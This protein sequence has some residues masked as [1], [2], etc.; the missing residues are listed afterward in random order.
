MDHWDENFCDK[1]V[2]DKYR[3]LQFVFTSFNDTPPVFTSQMRGLMY[4]PEVAPT[5]GRKHWQGWVW[6]KNAHTVGQTY[7]ALNNSWC[8]PARA[9]YK[10]N[11]DYIEGPYLKGSKSKPI[12]VDF[13]QFGD[14]PEQ[15]K[16]TDL[17]AIKDDIMN[18]KNVQDICVESPVIYHQYGRTLEKLE[19]ISQSTMCRGC[20]AR[21]DWYVTQN[22]D[23][24]KDAYYLPKDGYFDMYKL[25]DTV[26]IEN[27]DNIR[28]MTLLNLA[29]DYHAKAIRRYRPAVPFMATRIVIY[30]TKLPWQLCSDFTTVCELLKYT[31]IMTDHVWDKHEVIR[32]C[33]SFTD[34]SSIESDI[35]YR[36]TILAREL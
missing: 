16:R 22:R 20:V 34:D 35:D 19:D 29:R 3:G 33:A 7:K 31:T 24:I 5:T 17:I 10:E 13:K 23:D 8:S 6:W 11:R 9:T 28:I 2:N 18:G 26:V 1:E 27:L 14:A 21:I 36:S 15:G 25:Q 12:N 32:R 30:S 4:A